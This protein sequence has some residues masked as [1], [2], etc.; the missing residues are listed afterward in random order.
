MHPIDEEMLLVT[1][2]IGGSAEYKDISP[3]G[4]VEVAEHLVL[5]R[6]LCFQALGVFLL[7][8]CFELS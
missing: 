4:G 7:R 2:E 8:S 1:G 5:S 6:N 3:Q